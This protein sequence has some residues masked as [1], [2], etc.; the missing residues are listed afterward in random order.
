MGYIFKNQHG[1]VTVQDEATINDPKF[2]RFITPDYK[3]LFQIAD[4]EQVLLCYPNGEKTAYTCKYLDGYHFM[5]GWKA[6]HI[7]EFAERMRD[8]GIRV[9]ELPQK[10][11]IW[12]NIDLDL[13][14]WEGLREEYPDYDEKQLTEEMYEINNDYLA[15]ERHNLRIQCDNDIIVFGNIERWNGRVQGYKII[16]SGKISDCLYTDCDMAEWYVDRDGDLCSTQIHHDGTNYLYYRKFK[17]GLSNDDR[18]DFLDKFYNGTATQEDI[19]RVTD[20]L[21]EIIG[22]VYGWELPTVDRYSVQQR[23]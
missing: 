7:C 22:K 1:V 3:D 9:L 14:D 2:I 8:N 17:N 20:K 16:E 11:M 4:G 21:G 12:S 18:E 10:R 13:K 6:Y 15:E 19:D 23:E 5:L